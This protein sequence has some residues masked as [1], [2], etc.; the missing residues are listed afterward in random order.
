MVHT[1]EGKGRPQWLGTMGSQ[2][3]SKSGGALGVGAVAAVLFDELLQA[4]TRTTGRK[5]ERSARGSIAPPLYVNSGRDRSRD[6][7]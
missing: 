6:V 5:K 4:A 2:S 3:S 1:F 7:T